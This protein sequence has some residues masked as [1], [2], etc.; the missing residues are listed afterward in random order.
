MISKMIQISRTAEYLRA[1]PSDMAS[2]DRIT[3][4]RGYAQ[5]GLTFE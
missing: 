4:L 1:E 5:D 3:H 2:A